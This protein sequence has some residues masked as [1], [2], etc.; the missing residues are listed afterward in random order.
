MNDPT[1]VI[2]V[3]KSSLLS[4]KAEMLRKQEEVK[5]KKLIPFVPTKLKKEQKSSKS[6]LTTGPVVQ[7][8]HEVEDSKLL[9]RSRRILEKKAKYYDDMVANK[10]LTNTDSN[11]LVMFSKKTQLSSRKYSDEDSDDE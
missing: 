11:S 7:K 9:S 6:Q 5:N 2:E 1:K 3:E 10:G 8:Y 4:L